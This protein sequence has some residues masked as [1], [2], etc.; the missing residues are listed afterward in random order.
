M[1]LLSIA[2]KRTDEPVAPRDRFAK[3]FIA[4]RKAMIEIYGK[5]CKFKSY[6]NF[7]RLGLRI[8]A[9]NGYVSDIY[10]GDETEGSE[11]GLFTGAVRHGNRV[12]Y[13][14]PVTDSE[15][16]YLTVDYA[17]EFVGRVNALPERKEG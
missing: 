11:R 8:E 2:S 17:L 7:Y 13:D 16:D 9:P 15:P 12:C 1:D 5:D 14:T 4:L 6:H 10:I 3:V